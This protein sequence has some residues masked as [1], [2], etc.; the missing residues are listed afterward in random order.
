MISLCDISSS[1]LLGRYFSTL[2]KENYLRLNNCS[3]QNI[4][5]QKCELDG[6]LRYHKAIKHGLSLTFEFTHFTFSPL[7]KHG[8]E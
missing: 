1:R 8:I 3:D 2:D 7:F 4:D 6:I 5:L